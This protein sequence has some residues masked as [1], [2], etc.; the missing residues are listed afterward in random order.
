[1]KKGEESGMIP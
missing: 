1:L